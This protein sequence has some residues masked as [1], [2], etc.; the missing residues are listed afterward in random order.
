MLTQAAVIWRSDLDWRIHFK[1]HSLILDLQVEASVPHLGGLCSSPHW[2][3]QQRG[4]H[5]FQSKQCT[6]EQRRS[7]DAFYYQS[8]TWHLTY[9]V[10]YWSPKPTLVQCVYGGWR[11]GPGIIWRHYYQKGKITGSQFGDWLPQIPFIITSKDIKHLWVNLS[12][13]YLK[14]PHWNDKIIMEKNKENLNK[15]GCIQCL[16]AERLSIV[17]IQVVN[18]ISIIMSPHFFLIEIDKLTIKVICKC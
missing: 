9:A 3:F 2:T 15:W 4:S 11:R 16:W 10:F 5:V 18:I 8:Q 6:R 14:S 13:A 1:D 17:K 12:K 7:H